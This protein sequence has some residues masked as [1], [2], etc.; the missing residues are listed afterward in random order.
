VR[1]GQAPL[2][3]ELLAAAKSV[4]RPDLCDA[5][6]GDA[7]VQCP[8]PADGIGAFAGPTVDARDIAGY[9]AD[10]KG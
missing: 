6:L 10:L 9:L 1:W 4:V 5:A 7:G 2:S 3:V 8:A